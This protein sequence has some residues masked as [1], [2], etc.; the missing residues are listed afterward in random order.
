VHS[1]S[2]TREVEEDDVLE[3]FV[4]EIDEELLLLDVVEVTLMLLVDE[5]LLEDEVVDFFVDDEDLTALMSRAAFRLA[6]A[7]FSPITAADAARLRD[8]KAKSPYLGNSIT[9]GTKRK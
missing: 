6:A 9:S 1:E 7:S 3:V 4:D 2:A 5:A 8:R